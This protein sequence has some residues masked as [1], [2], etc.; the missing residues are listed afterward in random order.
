M[1]VL[2]FSHLAKN[3][4]LSFNYGE[5]CVLFSGAFASNVGGIQCPETG[6]GGGEEETK[7]KSNVSL[8]R[9]FKYE[10]K[11]GESG[12]LLSP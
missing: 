12:Y 9:T 1:V 7:G 3:T 11:H 5:T 8:Q 2:C 6:K 4:E 10:S